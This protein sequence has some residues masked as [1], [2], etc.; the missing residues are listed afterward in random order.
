MIDTTTVAKPKAFTPPS[1]LAEIFSLIKSCYFKGDKML[2][3]NLS[4]L[5]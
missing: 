4:L 5:I 1:A 2:L 3:R